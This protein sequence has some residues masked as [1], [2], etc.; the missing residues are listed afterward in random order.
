MGGEAGDNSGCRGVEAGSQVLQA[1][2]VD[3]VASSGQGRSV[4]LATT[5]L[6]EVQISAMPVVPARSTAIAW[7]GERRRYA[8]SWSMP[9]VVRASLWKVAFSPNVRWVTSLSRRVQAAS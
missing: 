8:A 6:R 1:C 5:V 3:V 4:S 2:G 9:R 7:R